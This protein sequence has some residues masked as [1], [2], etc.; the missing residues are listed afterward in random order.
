MLFGTKAYN[1]ICVSLDVRRNGLFL[2]VL[3]SIRNLDL[4]LFSGNC[5]CS[6]K[7]DTLNSPIYSFSY[8]QWPD[9]HLPCG[10]YG[11]VLVHLFDKYIIC[12]RLVTLYYV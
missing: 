12:H 5:Q 6:I 1:F 7:F 4:F 9:S 8:Y 2:C 3:L 10:G 11:T